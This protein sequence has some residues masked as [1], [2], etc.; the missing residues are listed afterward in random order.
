MIIWTSRQQYV[1]L[2][3]QVLTLPVKLSPDLYFDV[4]IAGSLSYSMEGSVQLRI[5]VAFDESRN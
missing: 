3:S 4:K 5:F 2:S 1:C